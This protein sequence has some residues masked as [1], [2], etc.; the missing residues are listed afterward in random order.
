MQRISMVNYYDTHGL[1]QILSI[2]DIPEIWAKENPAGGACG[3]MNFLY[4]LGV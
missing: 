2:S 3:V 1:G 4:I